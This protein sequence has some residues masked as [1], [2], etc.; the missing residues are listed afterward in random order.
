MRLTAFHC[1]SVQTFLLIVIIVF[2]LFNSEYFYNST[3]IAYYGFCISV[4]LFTIAGSF[5]LHSNE[6]FTFKIPVILFGLWCLYVLIN[7]L[8]G[9]ATLVFTIYSAAL[10]FLLF[11]STILFGNHT[12][13][14]KQFLIAIAVI[15]ALESLYCLMQYLGLSN[16]WSIY[17]KVTGS[18]NNPNVTAV[19]LALTVPVFLYL[20]KYNYKKIIL[21][22][23][24]LLFLALLLL[25]CR[26][27]FIGVFFSVIVYYS[28]EYQLTDWIRNKK[29][30]TSVKALLVLSLLIIIPACSYLYNIKKDSAD[31]RKFIWKVSADMI[32]EKPFTGYG[33]GYF[34]KEYNLYQADYIKNGALTAEESAHAGPVIMP[35]NELLLNAVEGGS[36][37]LVLL[38]LFFASLIFTIKQKKRIL[39]AAE[40]TQEPIVKN[41]IYN[42]AYAGTISFIFMS[43]VNST[44]EIIPLMCLMILYAAI[45]CSEIQPAGFLKKNMI[46]SIVTKSVISVI[47]LYLLYLLIGMAQADRQNKKAQLFKESGNYPKA[48]QIVRSLESS[49]NENSDYWQN[50]GILNFKTEHFREASVCFEKAKKFSSLPPVYLG[51]GKVHEKMKQ[52]PQAIL[53]YQT[54]TALYPSKFQYRML[55]LDVYLKNKD[56]ANAILTAKKIIALKPKIASEEVQEYKNR[57]RFLVQ[58]LETQ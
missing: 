42:L 14:I 30:S 18:W 40:T 36:I 7:Y 16:S 26:T 45:I 58:K 8:T 2:S 15:V 37:G 5:S 13:K 1:S 9:N 56:T 19:F 38:L 3:S 25:K 12:F 4:F 23:F 31:G 50:Y 55:L 44:T 49:L 46:I 32:K 52:Y 22:V 28:L 41:S 48:L 53:E 11:K 24:I 47:S 29:N 43:M 20:L 34:E 33:Y 6:K 57:C 17:Y 10:Y 51:A 27:A 35:H 54:L 39:N 21:A